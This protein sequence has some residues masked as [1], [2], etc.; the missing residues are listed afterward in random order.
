MQA[1]SVPAVMNATPSPICVV[2]P[3]RVAE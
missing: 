3:S 1:A 2:V